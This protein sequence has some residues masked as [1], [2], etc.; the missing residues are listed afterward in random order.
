MHRMRS[1]LRVPQI[2]GASLMTDIAALTFPKFP[3]DLELHGTTDLDVA[4]AI[5]GDKAFPDRPGEVIDIG[6][7][8][9]STKSGAPMIFKAGA[10]DVKVQFSA[11]VAASLGIFP[12]LSGALSSLNLGET[13]GLTLPT[14][15]DG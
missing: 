15:N 11:G 13:P 2:A 12:T 8:G 7:I 9:F 3:K 1:P 4:A 14:S 6:H 10:A 5:A